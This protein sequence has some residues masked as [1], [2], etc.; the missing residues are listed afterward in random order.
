MDDPVR[1]EEQLVDIAELC[2]REALANGATAAETGVSTSTGLSVTVRMRD[3]ETIEHIRDKSVGVTVYIGRRK[4]SASSSDFSAAALADT[5][6][7]ACAIARYTGEDEYAGLADAALMATEFPDLDLH[8]PW[9]VDAEDAISI[10]KEME[11][12]ARDAD[13]RIVNTE[14]ATLGTHETAHAY[15]NS[16]GFVGARLSTRH[17][18]S[19]V[20][21]AQDDAG[22]QRDYWYD[23]ARCAGDMLAPAEIGRMAAERTVARLSPRRVETGTMPVLFSADIASSLFGHLIGAIRGGALYRKATFL[24]DRLDTQ[25]FPAGFRIHEQPLLRRGAGSVAYDGEGVATRDRDIVNDGVLKGYVLSSYSARRLGLIT[26][27]NAGGVH[28]LTIAP[29]GRSREQLIRQMHRGL[30]VT[31]LMGMGVNT[32]TG[33]YSR[34]MGGYWIDGG[35]IQFPVEEITIAGNLKDMFMNIVAVGSDVDARGNTRTGSVLIDSMTVAG[36]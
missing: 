34:G 15:A 13:A 17:S 31:E 35:E 20:V 11:A 2:N 22:M 1:L 25:I 9:S 6:K 36:S 32:V 18:L 10:A 27:A 8:H 5:V 16:H 26:T 3:V 23:T 30:L 24:L 4:G 12:T 28:N 14:G 29:G 19:C 21:I 33:D 7:A